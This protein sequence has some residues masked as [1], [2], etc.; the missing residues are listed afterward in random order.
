MR[1]A[2][3][4][5]E[6]ETTGDRR[7]TRRKKYLKEAVQASQEGRNFLEM[8]SVAPATQQTYKLCYQA[9]LQWVAV[10]Q[11]PISTVPELDRA[12]GAY[13]VKIFDGLTAADF[14][15]V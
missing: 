7:S 12:V 10:T 13:S 11:M 15:K 9:F 14:S 8:K 5:R 3:R 2:K 1:S 6:P 4:V